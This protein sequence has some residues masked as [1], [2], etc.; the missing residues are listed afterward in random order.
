MGNYYLSSQVDNLLNSALAAYTTT[1]T[2]NNTLANYELKS[3][4]Q[5]TLSNYY[6]KTQVDSAFAN[7]IGTTPENLNSLQELA[8]S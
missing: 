6:T 2:L 7:L 5:S 8:T 3:D 1:S 4:L